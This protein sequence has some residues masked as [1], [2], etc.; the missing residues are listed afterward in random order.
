Y[1]DRLRDALDA[2]ERMCTPNEIRVIATARGEADQWLPL[3]YDERD[4]LWKRFTRVE[5]PAPRDSAIAVLLDE[6]VSRAHLT[7][8][9]TEFAAIARENDGT[10]ANVVLNLQRAEK[11]G[12]SLTLANYT[13]TLDG[14]W[15][16]VYERALRQHPAVR[17]IY[18]AMDVLRQAGIELYEWMVEPTA[19]LLWDGNWLQRV[20]RYFSIKRA[21]RYLVLEEKVLARSDG[22][23]APRDGQIEAKGTR[24]RA[25]RFKSLQFELM[26]FATSHGITLTLNL[27]LDNLKQTVNESEQPLSVNKLNEI[28]L[29]L[30]LVSRIT[31]DLDPPAGVEESLRDTIANQAQN[32]TA[33]YRLGNLQYEKGNYIEAELAYNNA[34]KYDSNFTSAYFS[35]GVL[36]NKPKRY[37][38]AEHAFRNVIARDPNDA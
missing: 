17:Y 23:L 5:L 13:A 19:L 2:F 26:N 11:E 27:M 12:K 10:F 7:A 14:S 28:K 38:E 36:M 29:A 25:E 33:Y 18:D 34:I 30:S 1:H 35:L 32:A 31:E 15:R 37:S 21:L 4:E 20:R 3:Q 24:L 9:R 8:E 16:E 22:K 6:E